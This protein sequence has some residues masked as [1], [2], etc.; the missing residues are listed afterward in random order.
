MCYIHKKY[1]MALL[2]P[3]FNQNK[4]LRATHQRL[5]DALKE[6]CDKHGIEYWIDF[7]TLLGAE[8]YGDFIPWDDDIDV[9]MPKADYKKFL[10]VAEKELPKDIFL[11][12]P[13]TD[14]GYKQNMAKL[15]DCY[16]TLLEHHEDGSEP[17]HHGIYI[18]VF[19]MVYYPRLPKLVRKVLMRTTVRSRHK[20][21]VKKEYVLINYPIYFL[22]KTAWF[23]LKPFTS[24]VFGQ[25]P[26]DN[27]Y[28]YVMPRA[29]LYPLKQ[30]TFAGK[31]YPAP[32][33]IPEYLTVLYRKY[34]ANPP[35]ESRFSHAKEILVDVPCNHP[36]ALHR[37]EQ[38][39]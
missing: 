39:T 15:R 6:I 36:R 34:S 38:R 19:P 32:N 11:Q 24:D 31:S 10:E 17:Y 3:D 28:M 21:Y 1:V 2:N 7:G 25:I 26:E 27:G 14:P 5:L 12:T 29:Y 30:I 9:S 4:P 37:N 8:L 33:K 13:K 22:C 16:S 23:L 35:M 18:D 20:A